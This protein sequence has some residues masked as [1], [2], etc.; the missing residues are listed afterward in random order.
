MNKDKEI[1]VL[2]HKISEADAKINT[3][4]K[5]KISEVKINNLKL[6]KLRY[7][8]QLTELISLEE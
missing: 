2:N 8:E 4:I 1:E 6:L 7:E 5:Y 3:F